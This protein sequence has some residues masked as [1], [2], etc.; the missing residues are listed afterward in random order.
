MQAGHGPASGT[1]MM[2]RYNSTF[3]VDVWKEL[4]AKA[5]IHYA[6][7]PLYSCSSPILD[8]SASG[9]S[10]T[11]D[12]FNACSPGRRGNSSSVAYPH[13][14]ATFVS[15]FNRSILI[16]LDR[17]ATKSIELASVHDY[18]KNNCGDESCERRQQHPIG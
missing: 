5:I 12:K 15:C 18:D 3:M 16:A 1:P 10:L 4:F 11:Q 6:V 13:N 17:L 9:C 8:L 14:R 7:R 2:G